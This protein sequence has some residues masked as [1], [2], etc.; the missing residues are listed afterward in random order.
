[1]GYRKIEGTLEHRAILHNADDKRRSEAEVNTEIRN[2]Q[3][4]DTNKH[5]GSV[6]VRHIYYNKQA[7]SREYAIQMT[8]R[9]YITITEFLQQ[10][11]EMQADGQNEVSQHE[12][13]REEHRAWQAIKRST[14][15]SPQL[16][17]TDTLVYITNIRSTREK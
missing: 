7:T 2:D 3:A 14:P 16:A 8:E 9:N 15:T 6:R 10:L 12:P 4:K 11:E 17:A 13:T 1:V 5:N